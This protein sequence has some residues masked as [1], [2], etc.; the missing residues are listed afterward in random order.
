MIFNKSIG[1]RDLPSAINSHL[2]SNAD[3]K[4]RCIINQTGNGYGSLLCLFLPSVTCFINQGLL[5][6]GRR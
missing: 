4:I 6:N 1:N 2:I 3:L 5:F